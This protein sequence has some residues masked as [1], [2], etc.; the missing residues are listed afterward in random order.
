MKS[1]RSI[2]TAIVVVLALLLIAAGVYFA[3]RSQ[4]PQ[5]AQQPQSVVLYVP[6]EQA[7]SLTATGAEVKNSSDQALIDGLI[8]AGA[9]PAGTEV[10]S[11]VQKDDVLTL[12]MNAA[13]GNAVRTSGTAGE[14]MLVYAV[15]NTFVQARGVQSVLLTVEGATLETGHAVYDQPLEMA[16]TS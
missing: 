16:Y 3:R 9:L 5:D 14:T 13:Y 1:T 12:D 15:V 8:A 2:R 6:D 11:S 7:Q 10:Q 4:T